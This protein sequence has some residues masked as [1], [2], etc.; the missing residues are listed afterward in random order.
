MIPPALL[1][2]LHNCISA[3]STVRK[4][5]FG[6]A[7]P[8]IVPRMEPGLEITGVIIQS[9]VQYMFR[10][11]S[12]IVEIDIYRRW[13]GMDT[14][15]APEI[16]AGVKLYHQQWDWQMRSFEDSSGPRIWSRDLSDFFDHTN[17]GSSRFA[18]FISEVEK[19]QDFLSKA[20]KEH[21]EEHQ[22]VLAERDGK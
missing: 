9:A 10:D 5:V 17:D 21:A 11:S 8:N 16:V 18:Y 19:I 12:Y 20:V 7:Y 14:A 6:L 1:R 13:V 3:H 2:V 22:V 15:P 4:D